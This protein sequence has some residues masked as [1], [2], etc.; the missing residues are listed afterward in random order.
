M[1]K[2]VSLWH[3][4]FSPINI[5]KIF[6]PATS[7]GLTFVRRKTV[8]KK[9]HSQFKIPGRQIV[10]Y[11]HSGCGKT[12]FLNR[13]FEEHNIESIIIQC[14]ANMS[15]DQLLLNTFD[16]L[17]IY[18]QDALNISSTEKQKYT[19]SIEAGGSGVKEETGK[20]TTE[21]SNFVRLVSP[22]LTSQRLADELGK[23]KK[24]LVVED[25]HKLQEDQKKRL[26]DT[27]KVFVDR[28]NHYPHLKL[29]CT[30]AVDT[31]REIVKLDNNLKQRVYECEIPLLTDKELQ[32]IVYRG[33]A[34]LNIEMSDD[35]VERIVHYSN[36][37]G[38]IAHQLSYDVCDSEDISKTQLVKKHLSGEHFIKAVEAYIDAR[39][40]SLVEIYERAVK[41]SLGW[42]ILSA[43]SELPQSKLSLKKITRTVN[44]KD[45]PFTENQIVL[46]LAELSSTDVGII[47]R[48]YNG[49]AYSISD[50]FW[51]AFIKMR[52]AKENADKAKAYH[53][54]NNLNLQLQ[55]QNDIEAMLLQIL[56]D[57]YNPKYG[58][59]R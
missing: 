12:T 1:N 23:S 35:L 4:V 38:S 44:T 41:D 56:L 11:G 18:Y 24:V 32:E 9:F 3:R 25:F 45:H 53:N 20:Q 42:Y 7:A 55:N 27:L 26:A 28:A 22:Q 58:V 30:G 51:G 49:A 48:N 47:R 46:K 59:Q 6:T 29:I 40:D 19:A 36:Q 17:G 13:Y 14:D 43:F 21:T 37:L 54:R 2:I 16:Q 10:V 15:F 34:L 31:A 52:I 57:K 8:E 39:S 5:E 33:C 50:P